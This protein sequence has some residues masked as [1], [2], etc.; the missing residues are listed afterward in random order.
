MTRS[1][2]APAPG[3]EHPAARVGSSSPRNSFAPAARMPLLIL[4][5]LVAVTA[6]AGG[7]ALIAG[8]VYPGAR[9]AIV[10]PAE[11][12]D[13]SPFASYLIPGLILACVLGG[14]H[15]LAFLMLLRRHRW[16]PFVSA[17]AGFDALIWIFVQMVIIPFSVLQ[18][19]YFL[20]GLAEIGFVMLGL[21]V[22]QPHV[23][24]SESARRDP[25]SAEG[26]RH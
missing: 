9:A 11:Y 15:L 23:V 6:F 16:S 26:S 8:S 21:G 10:P 18:A 24:G 20:A 14:V 3:S 17:V 13:G 25:L 2:P 1:T 19:V 4:Q 7:A 5:S 12:L 22:L